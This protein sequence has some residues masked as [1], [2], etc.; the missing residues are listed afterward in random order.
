E[1]GASARAAPITRSGGSRPGAAQ[2][3]AHV[4]GS[5]GVADRNVA[6]R[7]QVDASPLSAECAG[8][9]AAA[10]GRVAAP[11]ADSACDEDVAED[12]GRGEAADED[13]P[14]R[15]AGAALARG[16][17]GAVASVG[18]DSA[19]N[20]YRSGSRA[21]AAFD[22]YTSTAGSVHGCEGAAS[23]VSVDAAVHGDLAAVGRQ[24]HGAASDDVRRGDSRARGGDAV[25]VG[26]DVV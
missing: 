12:H 20:R 17:G 8:K 21:V 6:A 26:T 7:E 18:D 10:V 24:L 13:I 4:D 22:Q 15:P 2:A 9:G 1:A 16:R 5:V 19:G 3:A 11:R 25:A 23:A 14:R